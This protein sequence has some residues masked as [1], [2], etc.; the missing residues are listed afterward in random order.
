MQIA[1]NLDSSRNTRFSTSKEKEDEPFGR[2]ERSKI[3]KSTRS[4]GGGVTR[5]RSK[6][7][8]RTTVGFIT[9]LYRCRGL[10]AKTSVYA[11]YIL[12]TIKLLSLIHETECSAPDPDQLED[13]KGVSDPPTATTAVVLPAAFAN[14]PLSF[15]NA[16]LRAH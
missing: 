2:G 3:R 4:V 9:N 15:I 12:F 5:R 13:P 7:S 8:K 10:D 1:T 16:E 14:L 11:R 6:P